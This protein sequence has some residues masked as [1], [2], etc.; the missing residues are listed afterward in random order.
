MIYVFGVKNIF[1][2]GEKRSTAVSSVYTTF[3]KKKTTYHRYLAYP[4]NNKCSVHDLAHTYIST[5]CTCTL[6]V[7]FVQV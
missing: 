1:E 7:G 3:F 4:L 2:I 5:I 6:F